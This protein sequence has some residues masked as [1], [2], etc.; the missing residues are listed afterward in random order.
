MGRI[1]RAGTRH[2]ISA[3]WR[4]CRRVAATVRDVQIRVISTPVSS[5]GKAT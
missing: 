1:V 4:K 2:S 3:Y 5:V